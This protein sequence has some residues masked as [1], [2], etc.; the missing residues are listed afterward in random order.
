M[1]KRKIFKTILLYFA[2]IVVT[3]ANL[4]LI[5]KILIDII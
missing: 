5:F 3:I 2:I 4:L 1:K